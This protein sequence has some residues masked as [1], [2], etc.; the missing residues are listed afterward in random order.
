M[1]VIE[2]IST[3]VCPATS[4]RSP[5]PLSLCRCSSL[6]TPFTDS[7]E[8]TQPANQTPQAVGFLCGRVGYLD[9]GSFS[10]TCLFR[11]RSASW[12]GTTGRRSDQLPTQ[13]FFYHVP[14]NAQGLNLSGVAPPQQKQQQQQK[15][16]NLQGLRNKGF[17]PT[18]LFRSVLPFQVSVRVLRIVS[19]CLLEQIGNYGT[20]NLYGVIVNKL[21]R[22]IF[23]RL[24]NKQKG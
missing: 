14:M 24:F 20:G 23:L 15:T 11:R 7:A 8:R 9:G 10:I 6:P 3:D 4:L 18:P 1:S 22:I 12:L 13:M 16:G 17:G 19:S 5:P 21:V 2:P